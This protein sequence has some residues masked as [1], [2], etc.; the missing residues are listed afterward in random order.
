MSLRLLAFD[1]STERLSVALRHGPERLTLNEAGGTLASAR[2]VPA[3]LS[4]LAQAAL[5]LHELD[6]IAFGRGPGAFT[7]LRTSAAVAQGLALGAGVPVLPLDSL[8]IVAEDARGQLAGRVGEDDGADADVDIDAAMTVAVC[9]DARMAEVYAALYRWQGARWQV[10]VA[11][12]LYSL[13]AM[14]ALSEAAEQAWSADV[15]CG[16]ALSAFGDRLRWSAAGARVEVEADR[17]AALLRVTEQL[18]RDGHA[19]DAALALPLY[20]RDKVAQT[21]RERAAARAAKLG[22]AG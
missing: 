20:L 18:W 8:M 14:A 16:S 5:R 1:T 21:T 2:L 7:G 17:A 13:A 11:P 15:V 4:M 6:A 19:V 9:M 10:S 22:L 3:A 12:A